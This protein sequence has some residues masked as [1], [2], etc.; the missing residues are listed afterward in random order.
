MNTTFKFALFILL[1]ATISSTTHTIHLNDQYRLELTDDGE[2]S[3][4]RGDGQGRNKCT[5]GPIICYQQG[6][7]WRIQSLYVCYG[8]FPQGYTIRGARQDQE[9]QELIELSKTTFYSPKSNCK[10]Q[11][12]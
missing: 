12:E 2:F 10:F 4:L 11:K 1:L 9:R 3:L 5:I 8:T 6:E 7:D